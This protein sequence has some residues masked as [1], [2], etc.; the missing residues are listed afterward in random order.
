VCSNVV[1]NLVFRTAEARLLGVDGHICEL[2]L[3]LSVFADALV[4]AHN[5]F[6]RAEK[7]SVLQL[8]FF[9]PQGPELAQ[10]YAHA[11]TPTSTFEN[12]K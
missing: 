11:H 1:V 6:E 10:E 8:I 9:S 4:L 7:I 3:T 5:T 2:Q 12:F